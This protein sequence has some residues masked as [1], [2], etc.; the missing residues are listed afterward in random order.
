MS[1][2]ALY[3]KWRP[4]VFADVKGQ[5]PIVRTLKNQVTSGKIG[6]AYLFCGSRGTG[7]TTIAKIFARAV[8]CE[9]PVDGEPCGECDTCKAIAAGNSMNVFELDAASNNG[10]DDI[11]EL[12]G[13]V[14]Y[15]PAMGKYSVYIL[16]EAHMI[17]KQGF[18]AF[19]K[20]L[21]EPPEHVI[22]ILATTEPHKLLPT[23]LSRC[24]Q[25][26]F[27]RIDS[28][29]I[30]ERLKELCQAEGIDAEDRALEYIARK[31]DGGMRDAISLLDRA[32]ATAAGKLDYDTALMS[33][34]AVSNDLFSRYVRLACNKDA[35]GLLSL[36]EE[37]VMSGKELSQFTQ[38]LVWYYRNIL[39]V[40]AAP[41]D[42][43]IV[44]VS[45]A[46][47]ER[48]VEEASHLGVNTIMRNIRI[49]S[50]C[51]NMMRNSINKRVEL[52]V[53]TI[54]IVRPEAEDSVES[55]LARVSALEQMLAS[56]EAPAPAIQESIAPQ[57]VQEPTPVVEPTTAPTPA[58]TSGGVIENWS[59]LCQKLAPFDKPYVKKSVPVLDGEVLI[60][61][62][63]NAF[64]KKQADASQIATKMQDI[65]KEVLGISVSA[66]TELGDVA[67]KSEK[68]IESND[69]AIREVF[70][71][72][73]IEE[74]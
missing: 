3:R 21:E 29:T 60:I 19:L 26:D 35:A 57:P 5:E 55:V 68:Q 9:H 6:H 39:L 30:V 46:D 64:E 69:Q 17:S 15:A 28:A 71:G 52:E 67:K 32:D 41:D 38:D 8:N 56:G 4:A 25:Y 66:R 61:N 53:A 7:K 72:I 34:G 22:F 24:Q 42:T 37:V 49:L 11:R 20:T 14:Q 23:I 31:A 45:D 62:Y 1:Y 70:S 74:E 2:Q 18:N 48:L 50:E 43:S 40:K 36:I 33:L 12:L 47:R 27:K 63:A 13:D 59:N 54:K 10:V 73:E 16:D 44:E 65:I 58:P 51:F